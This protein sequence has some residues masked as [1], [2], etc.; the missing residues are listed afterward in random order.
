MDKMIQNKIDQYKKL[1]QNQA[2][3]ND[4]VQPG[5]TRADG[6]SQVIR[7]KKDAESFMTELNSIIKR[8]K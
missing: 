2:K 7:S 3:K 5:N 6:L 1:A 8:A 4:T